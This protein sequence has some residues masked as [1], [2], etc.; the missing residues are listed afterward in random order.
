[1]PNINSF[2]DFPGT[3]EQWT[4]SQRRAVAVRKY[5]LKQPTNL[6]DSYAFINTPHHALTAAIAVYAQSIGIKIS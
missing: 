2:R 4:D 6:S 3:Q 1:M 5:L